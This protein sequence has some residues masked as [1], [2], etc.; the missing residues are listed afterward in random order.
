MY[1]WIRIL[2]AIFLLN[3]LVGQSI[4]I[5]DTVF[6]KPNQYQIQLNPFIIDSSL[7]LFHNGKLV[8]DYQINTITGELILENASKDTGLFLASY[9]YINKP[10]PVKV[11]PLYESLPQLDSLMAIKKDSL[12][13]AKTNEML[14][15]SI[16]IAMRPA[17]LFNVS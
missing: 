11:G 9:Q 16:C 3:I 12:Q 10:I 4:S 5:V 8:E 14:S 17:R 6:V 7:F 1:R 15:A 13:N 2:P